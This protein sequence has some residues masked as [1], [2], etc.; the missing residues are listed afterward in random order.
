[1]RACN[2]EFVRPV[3]SARPDISHDLSRI[4]TYIYISCMYVHARVY[5][6]FKIYFETIFQRCQSILELQDIVISSERTKMKKL[7]KKKYIEIDEEE[8]GTC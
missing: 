6:F 1:M 2:N 4:R 7:K 3:N 8:R 5:R